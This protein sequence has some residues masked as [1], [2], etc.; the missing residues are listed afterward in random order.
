MNRQNENL[1]ESKSD[2]QNCERGQLAQ[3]VEG[4]DSIQ[5]RQ[6]LKRTAALGATLMGGATISTYLFKKASDLNRPEH[7][8][9]VDCKEA[10]ENLD[11]YIAGNLEANWIR[12]IDRHLGKCESCN[13]VYAARSAKLS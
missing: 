3:F 9:I 12:E 2:W 11:S 6:F 10:I 1:Q 13:N 4:Q 7:I 8:V 5:R